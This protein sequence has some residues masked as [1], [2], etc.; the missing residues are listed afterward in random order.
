VSRTASVGLHAMR[1]FDCA[2]L[3]AEASSLSGAVGVVEGRG[4]MKTISNLNTTLRLRSTHNV[5]V[6]VRERGTLR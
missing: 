1:R 6:P 4:F 5:P 3:S 2:A